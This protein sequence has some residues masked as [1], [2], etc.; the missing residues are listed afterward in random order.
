MTSALDVAS[1]RYISD[2][3][4][5]L[6]ATKLII[7]H[8]CGVGAGVGACMRGAGVQG[9]QPARLHLQWQRQRWSAWLSNGVCPP[10]TA[11]PMPCPPTRPC[12][13]TPLLLAPSRCRLST[14]RRADVIAVVEGGQVV[15]Q[16]SHEE[17]VQ[18]E[19][20]SYKRLVNTSELGST[21]WVASE[22]PDSSSDSE[23]EGGAAK[24][25]EAAAALSA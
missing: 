11:A 7:A 13:P 25:Q 6:T 14:V 19:G 22:A 16:G 24:Q 1:E 9:C 3:L 20:G 10:S 17:L 4:R 18:L 12:T 8:R 15:E 23:G 2:T 21:Y 5:R